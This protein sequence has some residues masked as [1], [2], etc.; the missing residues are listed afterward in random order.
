MRLS[1][2]AI[3]CNIYVYIMYIFNTVNTLKSSVLNS[4]LGAGGMLSGST[5]QKCSDFRSVKKIENSVYYFRKS[6][7]RKVYLINIFQVTSLRN[8]QEEPQLITGGIFSSF[9]KFRGNAM[10][11]FRGN[12]FQLPCFRNEVEELKMKSEI[13]K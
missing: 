12:I 9:R 10:N 8:S 13:K 1:T 6:L 2:T 7:L 11:N 4:R 5:F 3:I